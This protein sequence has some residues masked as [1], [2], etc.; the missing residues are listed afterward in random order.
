M[1]FEWDE[2]K[3]R[4]NLKKH[5]VSFD[6][7]MTFFGDPLSVTVADPEHS[8]DEYRFVDIGLSD[9][10]RLL[11]VAYTERGNHIRIISSRMALPAE[12]TMYEKGD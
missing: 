4:I 6:E 11:V 1:I 9:K 8:V 12:R 5:G 10:I 2:N 3:S 7:A